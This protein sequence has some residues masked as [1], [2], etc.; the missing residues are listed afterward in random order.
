MQDQ[1]GF[2]ASLEPLG[3]DRMVEQDYSSRLRGR[4]M[5]LTALLGRETR[6]LAL[7]AISWMPVRLKGG[8]TTMRVG[9]DQAELT[10]SKANPIAQGVAEC[11]ADADREAP[12]LMNEG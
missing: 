7:K 2:R 11:P 9:F 6:R 5:P 4:D 10:A 12:V 3:F 8:K 1:Y